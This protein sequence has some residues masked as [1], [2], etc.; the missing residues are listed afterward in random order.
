MRYWISLICLLN[1]F[2]WGCLQ[3][4]FIESGDAQLA[5]SA[6]TLTFD[7]V[8]TQVGSATRYF[9][10][11]N[12]HDLS[13][14]I[15]KVKLESGSQSKFRI[16][17]DGI[18]YPEGE[19]SD[20]TIWPNDSIYVFIEVTVDPN[21]PLSESPF[22]IH[23]YLSLETNGNIQKVVLEAWGQNANYI[24]NNMFQG[25]LALLTCDQS[26][27]IWQDPK[28]YVVYGVLLI[29]SCTLRIKEGTRIHL[30][31]GIAQN[32]LGTYNDGI[33]WTLRKGKL[34]LEGTFENPI[35]IQ[36]DRLED[37]YQDLGGQWAGL[38]LGAG[39]QGHQIENTEIKNSIVGLRV[40]SGA[41]VDIFNTKI[42][43]TS[44]AGIVG[45][46][47]VIKMKNSLIHSNGGQSLFF[48]YGG[49][50]LLDYCTISSYGNLTEALHMDNFSCLDPECSTAAVFSLNASFRNCIIA[51]SGTDEIS[52]IDATQGE[53]SL[54]FRYFFQ[55]CVV[56]VDELLDPGQ[57]PDF[58]D[59]CNNCYNLQ[60]SDLLFENIELSDYHL[61]SLSIAIE[62]ATPIPSITSDLEG[63]LRD[64]LQPDQG[65]YEKL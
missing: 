25:R 13:I 6:D 28:P 8:F 17:I 37:E 11:Y 39:S 52:L 4:K 56:R 46:H 33:L 42:F 27:V 48:S 29:D 19:A 40:D 23:E 32:D 55:N 60:S 10:I 36:G 1:I 5:F 38:R 61:D 47:A 41:T 63:N 34:I 64:P 26:E 43:N 7:T 35:I 14:G 53:N 59:H 31:G 15:S 44:S 57:F 3:E 51:G 20:I 16:N 22:V 30:H 2:T 49:T 9:K 62:Q 65:C 58:Y 18:S 50:Y 21:Q 24:P 45:E 54:A 12:K